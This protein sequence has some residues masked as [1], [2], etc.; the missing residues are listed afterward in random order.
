MASQSG[1]GRVRAVF[2][3]RNYR[4]FWI[5]GAISNSGRWMSAITVP[6][7]LEQITG[8]GLW[9][10]LA[11]F[12]QLLPMALV[13]PWA[14]SL[15]D[16]YPRRRILLVSQSGAALVAAVFSVM[17]AS[18]V[19][20]P[21]AYVGFS[22]VSG[23]VSGFSLPAW[24]AFV[25]ELVPRELLLG[26]ITLNST[27]FN[28]A[29]AVGPVAAGIVLKVAGP[30]WTFAIDA[31]AYGAVIGALLLIKVPILPAA[32][33]AGRKVFGEFLDTIGYIRDRPGLVTCILAVALIGGLGLPI[34]T[35]VVLFA[36]QVFEVD[37]DLFGLMVGSIGIGAVLAAPLVASVGSRYR[38]SRLELVSVV[39][40]GVSVTAF[41]L[42]PWFITALVSLA[43]VG[44]AHIITASTLN[45][46]LQL[47]VDEVMRGKVL[48]LYLMS[49]LAANPVGQLSLGAMSDVVG[50]RAAVATAGALLLAGALA[51]HTSGRLES[52]DADEAV[53]M[54]RAAP[55][56]D[57]RLAAPG[58]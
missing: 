10:G 49:L 56:T 33:R 53:V 20:S 57:G 1:I 5:G 55:A 23:L 38:R 30:A 18:G 35:L 6:Y 27:Q 14:G 12:A 43:V 50:P 48:S 22:V 44:A 8:K 2:A 41:A 28:A 37:E 47:Q 25:S 52:L 9:V 46:A 3:I 26:A 54:E 42:S 19:R 24:Q 32:N 51:L 34:V 58:G 15:A 21:W 17:W 4:L 40:Y 16:R 29:R 45:T 39:M 11:A 31:L 7:I 13:A 36:E